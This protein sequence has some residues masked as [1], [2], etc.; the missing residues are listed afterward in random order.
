[1]S[2]MRS[3]GRRMSRARN[4]SP[5]PFACGSRRFVSR[6]TAAKEPVNDDVDC[7]QVRQPVRSIQR[8]CL[9]QKVLTRSAV[10]QDS[11]HE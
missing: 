3:D 9:G 6:Y 4:C 7:A 11:N 10:S 5:R 1:M 8:V 2:G